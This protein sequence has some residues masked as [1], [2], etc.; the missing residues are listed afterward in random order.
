MTSHGQPALVC[1]SERAER[2][3][4]FDRYPRV[5]ATCI[6]VTLFMGVLSAL[7]GYLLSLRQGPVQ[8]RI[9]L[10]L[11][12]LRSRAESFIVPAPAG[13]PLLPVSLATLSAVLFTENL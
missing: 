11:K 7:S 8:T 6:A 5:S 2:I 4:K 9:R 1:R 13:W 10:K 12:A 3:S